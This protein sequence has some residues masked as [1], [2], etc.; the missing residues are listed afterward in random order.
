M[1]F[2]DERGMGWK[3]SPQVTIKGLSTVNIRGPGTGSYDMTPD[4]ESSDND[5]VP[6]DE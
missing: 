6:F 2:V 4:I 5:S 3:L 1:I